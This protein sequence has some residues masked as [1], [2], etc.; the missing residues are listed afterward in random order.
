MLNLNDDL[1]VALEIELLRLQGHGVI[2][3][4]QRTQ[5]M[6]AILGIQLTTEEAEYEWR[7]TN[8]TQAPGNSQDTA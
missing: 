4:D 7:A 3:D 2:T 8:P 5:I 6:Q 1:K